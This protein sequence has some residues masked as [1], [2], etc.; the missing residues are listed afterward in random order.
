MT[1]SPSRPSPA[2]SAAVSPIVSS[3]Q[4][5]LICV[6]AQD[7]SVGSATKQDCH[8]GAGTLHRAFSIFI[9]NTQGQV[10]LQQRAEGKRLW[11]AFWANSCFSHPRWGEEIADA[12]DRRLQQELGL[13]AQLQFLYKFEYAAQ[14][15]NLGSEHELCSVFVG[16]CDAPPQVNANEIASWRWVDQAELTQ[17]LQQEP[18]HYTPWLQLEWQRLQQDFSH[19]LPSAN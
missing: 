6:D 19:R 14:Y 5:L 2:A 4:E 8:D 15:Q 11:P 1:K 18:E 7:Q 13:Q 16:T 12:A 10:L 17:A 3:E 9:F